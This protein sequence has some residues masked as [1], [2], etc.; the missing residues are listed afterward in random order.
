MAP[1]VEEPRLHAPVREWFAAT[2]GTA[3]PVQRAGWPPILAGRSALLLEEKRLALAAHP[4]VTVAACNLIT[5]D[6]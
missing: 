4:R 5:I 1:A 2:F 3:T 6:K